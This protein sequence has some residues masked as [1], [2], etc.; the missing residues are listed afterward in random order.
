MSETWLGWDTLNGQSWLSP[1]S[2][3]EHLLDSQRRFQAMLA[4]GDDNFYSRTDLRMF[5]DKRRTEARMK[6]LAAY[7]QERN[8]DAAASQD[9]LLHA[10]AKIKVSPLN[11]MQLIK[12]Y[13]NLFRQ[14]Y[15]EGPNGSMPLHFAASAV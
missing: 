1:V 4:D 11:T 6:I 5:I 7:N 10:A 2:E 8:V 15:P 3:I 13:P 14:T 9:L 12:D